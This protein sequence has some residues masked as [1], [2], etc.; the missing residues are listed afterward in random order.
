MSRVVDESGELSYHPIR[1]MFD[2]MLVLAFVFGAIVVMQRQDDIGVVDAK[3]LQQEMLLLH[4][5][6][7]KVSNQ[8]LLQRLQQLGPADPCWLL[9]NKQYLHIGEVRKLEAHRRELWRKLAQPLREQLLADK[10][11]KV[12]G[13]D[14]LRFA[15]GRAVPVNAT[16]KDEI[17]RDAL[18]KYKA[19]YRRI[20]VEG[21]T[22]NV[23]IRNADFASNWELSAARAIWLAKEM[24][25]YFLKNKIPVGSKGV[26]IEAI[27]YGERKPL[28]PNTSEANR[29]K[30]R[31]IEV[32][33]ER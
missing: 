9:E 14:V 26:L 2:L 27:G 7:R 8:G 33:F 31:R 15:S 4:N 3:L 19:G 30:N 11:I 20:R 25:K 6:E 32:V 17:L 10:V 5:V 23:P 12:Y 16:R 13:Q 18:E 24:E 1:S 22:D 21:H 29:A 28:A